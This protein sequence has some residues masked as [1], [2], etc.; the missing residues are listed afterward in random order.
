MSHWHQKET[1]FEQMHRLLQQTPGL[2]ATDLAQQLGVP[3][4]TILRR[5]PG[6]EAAGYLLSEDKRGGLW[7]FGRKK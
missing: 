3:P 7:P 1:E 6:M 4:S 2:T 5:L